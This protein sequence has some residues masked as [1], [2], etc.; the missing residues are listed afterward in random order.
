MLLWPIEKVEAVMELFRRVT[1]A[2]PP[3]LAY[4]LFMRNAPPAPFLPEAIHGK[5]VIG[6]AAM[7]GGPV[8]RGMAAMQDVESFSEPLAD[9]I[10]PKPFREHQAFLDAGQPYGRRYY[11]KSVYLAE[12][13]DRV[14]EA[15]IAKATSFT[16]PFSSV[17]VPHLAGT[18]DPPDGN[19]SA[20]GYRDAAYLVNYQAS[21]EDPTED[22]THI[23]WARD[24]FEAMLPNAIGQYVNFMTEDEVRDTTR[25]AYDEETQRRLQQIKAKYDPENLFRMNKNIEPAE[26]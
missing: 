15:L 16:S 13:S 6:I 8:E 22:E 10:K 2:A 12:F 7:Y 3:E 14:Q 23:S 19:P 20:V 4:V 26:R 11:W 18:P 25:T 21:W 24:N 9:T 17:L 5:P 1:A